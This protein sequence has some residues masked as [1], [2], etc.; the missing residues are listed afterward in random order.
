[1]T[2]GEL[3]A[4][5][6]KCIQLGIELEVDALQ[7]PLMVRIDGYDGPPL[8]DHDAWCRTSRSWR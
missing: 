6:T 8:L 5:R 7:R 3:V 2:M 4:V 1:M